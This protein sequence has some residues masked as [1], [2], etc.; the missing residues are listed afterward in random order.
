MATQT[1]TL[2]LPAM[3][4]YHLTA[5]SANDTGFTIEEVA[6]IIEEHGPE[7]KVEATITTPVPEPQP[8][9]PEV[10]AEEAVV[11]VTAEGY[12][13]DARDGDGDGLVQEGTPFER[14]VDK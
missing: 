3:H 7:H 4:L 13:P 2:T 14:E 1:V 10:P 12:N 11:D 6:Q 9:Q 8:E 5:D